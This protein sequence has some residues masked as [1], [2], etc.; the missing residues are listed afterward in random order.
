VRFGILGTGV[1]GRTIA[2]RLDELGHNVVTGTP[3]PAETL[4]RTEPDTYGN[5]PFSAWQQ[6]H[7]EVKLGTFSEAAAHG[8]IIVN[9]TAGAVSLEAL[10]L[11]GQANLN[12]RF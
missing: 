2:T 6:E 12:G 10:E 1:V 11:A 5:P 4:A 7:S 3:D 9:A 8:E